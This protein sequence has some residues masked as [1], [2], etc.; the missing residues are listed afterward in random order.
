MS[1]QFEII[2]WDTDFFNFNV[3]RL[4]AD[5]LKDR[6]GLTLLEEIYNEDIKLAYYVSENPLSESLKENPFYKFYLVMTR[7]PIV[8]QLNEVND[9]H[10]NISF[11]SDDYPDEDLIKL[12]QLAG[13]QGRFGNDPNITKEQCDE[14]FENYIINSVNKKMATEVLV[15]RE[16]ERI[17]GFSTL[18]VGNGIGYA[19][20]FAVAREYEGKGISFALMRAAESVMF[21]KGVTKVLS[22][23]QNLNKKALAIY[24]RYGFEL[25]EPEYVYHLWQK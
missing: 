19:P 24:K 20:L 3:A 4:K 9:F 18:K 22:G 6:K 7:I 13:A 10:R 17:I 11:Y 16:N 25:K 5:T 1:E 12:A 21:S 14:I 23:T 2:S 8:K 15:Y